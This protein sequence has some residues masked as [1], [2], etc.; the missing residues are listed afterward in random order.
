MKTAKFIVTMQATFLIGLLIFSGA[1]ANVGQQGVSAMPQPDTMLKAELGLQVDEDPAAQK[2]MV[3]KLTLLAD[4]LSAAEQGEAPEA[5]LASLQGLG[6]NKAVVTDVIAS[7]EANSVNPALIAPL[8]EA[9]NRTLVPVNSKTSSSGMI[10]LMSVQQIVTLQPY[11]ESEIRAAINLLATG[12]N[13]RDVNIAIRSNELSEDIDT[14]RYLMPS[15]VAKETPTG[16]VFLALIK[17]P[18]S[19]MLNAITFTTESD[20]NSINAVAVDDIEGLAALR[21]TT[22]SA[23]TTNWVK[24][25]AQHELSSLKTM[26][27]SLP[28][29]GT[30]KASS[31]GVKAVDVDSVILNIAGQQIQINQNALDEI[32]EASD[33][34]RGF[35]TEIDQLRFALDLGMNIQDIQ[36]VFIGKAKFIETG[37]AI[38]DT[39][40]LIV[41]KGVTGLKSQILVAVVNDNTPQEAVVAGI[42]ESIAAAKAIPSLGKT[43]SAGLADTINSIQTVNELITG[44]KAAVVGF[45]QRLQAFVEQ[46]VNPQ[47]ADVTLKALTADAGKLATSYMAALQKDLA[48]ASVSLEAQD[49]DALSNITNLANDLNN[50]MNTAPA[51]IQQLDKSI[52][53]IT[54]TKERADLAVLKTIPNVLVE[55]GGD[56][57]AQLVA[58]EKTRVLSETHGKQ[59]SELDIINERVGCAMRSVN[60]TTLTTADANNAVAV[61]VTEAGR[62]AFEANGIKNVVMLSEIRVDGAYDLLSVAA[63]AKGRFLK[64]NNVSDASLDALMR[65]AYRNL[66]GQEMPADYLAQAAVVIN[67]VLQPVT[68]AYDEGELEAYHLMRLLAMIAA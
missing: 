9:I 60:V 52:A 5:L 40:F 13:V 26:S 17:H 64:A 68:R 57:D 45:V 23:V 30:A 14:P 66:T 49:V 58:A 65:S 33:Y 1:V 28:F 3:D 15:I 42:V 32:I 39:A 16:R 10:P 19:E 48:E 31:A 38:G 8:K 4:M 51:F 22:D 54:G 53:G 35:L 36:D 63:L 37:E 18:I 41:P 7:L 2:R 50:A 61:A 46:P 29:T 27:S 62:M 12:Q 34:N 59:V 55:A 11:T 67:V 6:S 56:M 24:M 21:N 25:L 44:Y 43:S 20:I 47:E